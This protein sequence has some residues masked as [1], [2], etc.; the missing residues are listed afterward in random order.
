MRAVSRPAPFLL[1]AALAA[2]SHAAPP[3][4]APRPAPVESP[5]AFFPL[6]VGNEWT[7]LDRSPQTPGDAPRRRTVRILSRDA[8]GYYRDSEKGELRVVPPC[9][10]DRVRRIVCA[11]FEVGASWS[12]VVGLGSTER[13]QIA[14]VGE[15]ATTP[16]GT[17][18]GCLRVRARNRAADDVENVLEITYAPGVGPVRIETFAVVKGKPVPQV[19]AE[20]AAYHLEERP[21]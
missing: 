15:T 7:Y 8:D 2:C 1:A 21:R 3:T 13:Y 20:L 6:A 17:F 10:Q 5:A 4:A 14:A 12:S 16:A 18:E 11:P 9:I 19:R